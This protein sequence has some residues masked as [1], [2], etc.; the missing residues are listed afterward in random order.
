M[1]I[2][3]LGGTRFFGR[4]F[5]EAAVAGGHDLT[6]FNRGESGPDLFPEVRTL[7]GDRDGGLG[8]LAGLGFDA[9]LDTCGYAPRVVRASA[10][11]LAP[12]VG[13]YVFVSSLSVYASERDAHQDESAPVGT[14][15]DPTV[16]EVTPETYGPLKALCEREVE[17]ALPDRALVVRPG[18][19]VGPHD[20][21]DR[22]TYWVLR[23][24]R[25]GDVL[26]PNGPG[27]R[28]QF[29]DARDLA[30]WIL[31]MV[32][33]GATGVFN[34]TGPSE[35]LALGTLLDTC[36]DVAGGDARITWV[37]ESFLLE[38]GVEPWSEMPLWIPGEEGVGGH[39]FDVDKALAEGLAFRPLAGTVAD[40][41]AWARGRPTDAPLRAGLQPDREA[42]LLRA[43]RSRAGATHAS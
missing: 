40:T 39:S 2:L 38:Q 6:L 26:A 10:E 35:P 27:Y 42:E 9:V 28:V 1:R 36:R 7:R 15:A 23:V 4:A 43:W 12:N 20:A 30:A 19:I 14:I 18:L 11:L 3:V 37:D 22:F 5:V 17:R 31:L 33:R 24:A 29:V 32:E 16:E 34:A 13:R 21:S 25:G 8:A 41:L